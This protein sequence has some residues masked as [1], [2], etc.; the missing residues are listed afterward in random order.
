MKFPY[1]DYQVD[2]SLFLPGGVLFRPEV[3]V[4][5]IGPT[6]DALLMGLLDT[7]AAHTVLPWQVAQEIG[8]VPDESQELPVAGFTGEQLAIAPGTVDFQIADGQQVFQWSAVVGFVQYPDSGEE[9]AILGLT[10]CLDFFRTTFD[11]DAHQIELVP[12]PSFPGTV[13]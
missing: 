11:G 12:T 8:I 3:L 9:E 5:I 1:E 13:K 6:G 2:P 4:R 7:G 10:G